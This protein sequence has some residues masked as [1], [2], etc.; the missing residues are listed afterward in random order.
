MRR[1][2]A[3][4]PSALGGAAAP[5]RA[6]PPPRV[7][8]TGGFGGCRQD[9]GTSPARW[10]GRW[11]S[12]RT[13]SMCAPRTTASPSPKAA[14]EVLD[15][16]RRASR[17]RRRSAR[18]PGPPS[19]A[20][21]PRPSAKRGSRSSTRTASGASGSILGS[22]AGSVAVAA[23]LPSPSCPLAEQS[24]TVIDTARHAE[25]ERF[26]FDER[27]GGGHR[28]SGWHRA[29]RRPRRRAAHRPEPPRRGPA[30]PPRL[31]RRSLRP[32]RSPSRRCRRRRSS[33]ASLARL[34]LARGTLSAPL[35][36]DL[37]RADVRPLSSRPRTCSRGLPAG[38]A[39]A[40]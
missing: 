8:A 37:R 12:R 24:V 32:S 36:E 2:A 16:G 3:L 35:V 11:R 25:I 33:P 18:H 21:P 1:P 15:A 13:P 39:V 34:D 19:R 29:P 28:R 40:S 31:C 26:Y 4:L 27:D 22:A 17:S 10:W 20:M 23:P 38:R 9:G 6:Q 7:R 5:H 14:V 30:D